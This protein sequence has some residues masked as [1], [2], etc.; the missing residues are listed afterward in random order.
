MTSTV[1]KRPLANK[2]SLLRLGRGDPPGGSPNAFVNFYIAVLYAHSYL[3]WLVIAMTL[4]V[5]ARSAAAWVNARAWTE[6]DAR[7]HAVYV[8]VVDI[9]FT[10]GALL[11]LFLSPFVRVFYRL[12]G[13]YHEPLLRFFGI[14]HA[15]GMFIAVSLVHIGEIRARRAAD[16]GLIKHRGV[17][18]ATALALLAIAV[19]VPWPFLRYGRPLLRG[20]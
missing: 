1:E 12:P 3:R 4:L 5:I 20:L 2:F 9:Q 13:A 17:C 15:L 19:S 11:Y 7:T 8:R 16:S 18:I 10:L 14:E 6:N